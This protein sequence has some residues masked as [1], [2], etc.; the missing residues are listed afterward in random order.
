MNVNW[1]RTTQKEAAWARAQ[2]R[3]LPPGKA[4]AFAPAVRQVGVKLA[5]ETQPQAARQALE[6]VMPRKQQRLRVDDRTG[7]RRRCPA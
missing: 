7:R 3:T 4:F 1:M 2:A 5:L 6:L